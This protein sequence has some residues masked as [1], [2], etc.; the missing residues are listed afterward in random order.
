MFHNPGQSVVSTDQTSSARVYTKRMKDIVS[1]IGSAMLT[2]T[3]AWYKGVH[4]GETDGLARID[5]TFPHF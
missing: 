5:A 4:I 3:V 2:V 1:H